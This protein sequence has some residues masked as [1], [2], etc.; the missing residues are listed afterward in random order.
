[1]LKKYKYSLWQMTKRLLRKAEPCKKEIILATIAS[2]VGNLSQMGLMGFGAARVITARGRDK[3]NLTAYIAGFVLSAIL[4]VVC[5][6]AEGVISHVGAYSL[7][8]EMRVSMFDTI[9]KLAPACLTDRE[10]GDIMNIAVSDIETIEFFFAHTIGPM[11]TVVILPCVT[12]FMAYKV[13]PAFVVALLPVYIVI[14][15]VFPLAA[16]RAGRKTGADFRKELGKLKSI[17]LE[18]IYGIK[19]IQ[20][21]GYG[22]KALEKMQRTN[23]Q[24]NKAS[25]GLTIHRRTVA[26]APT[27]FIY[28]ARIAILAV[29]ADLAAKGISDPFGTIVISFVA[30]ASFSSTQSLT[31]VVSSLLETYAA[32]ER[33]FTLEDTQ[34]EVIPPENPVDTGKIEKI[35]FQNVDFYYTNKEKLILNNF[36]LKIEGNEKLGIIGESGAGKSTILRLLLHF[37]NVKSGKILINGKDIRQ[38]D[39]SRLSKRIA[40]LEQDTFLFSGSIADN[41]TLGRKGYT[42][43][44]IESAAQKAGIH[45]FIISLPDGYDTEMGSM[46]QRL[47]GGEKQRIGIARVMLGNPDLIVMDEPTSSLDVIHEEELLKTLRESCGDK[48]VIIVSH[49]LSTL[50][51]CTSI[52]NINNIGRQEMAVP[53]Y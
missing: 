14:S 13:S 11:F 51:D 33:I 2:I 42:Q 28:L 48:M 53:A 46:G 12:L 25:H 41:I 52:I 20:I 36:N 44:D 50:T 37:W 21:F 24:I 47:S 19:D 4:I 39:P 31:T 32:A 27:F 35:E 6:Y 3:N 18:S 43:S 16:V 40:V 7:L 23:R 1:M 22:S 29:A 9:R 49:R 15:I 8:A 26:S 45:Q 10:K 34:P 30:T 17:V 38:I 5:R